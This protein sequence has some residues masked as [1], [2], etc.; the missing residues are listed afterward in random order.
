MLTGE[1]QAAAYA[2]APA[3]VITAPAGTGKTEVLVRRAEQF[4]N[5]PASGYKRVL[6]VT[7]TTRA[8]AEFTSRLQGSLGTAMSRVQAETVHGFAQSILTIHGSHVGLP[9]DFQVI[10]RDEDRAELLAVYDPSWQPDDDLSLFRELDIARAKGSAHPHLLAWSEA[11]AYRGAVDFNE[12]ITKA[13]QVLQINAI[14]Q[15]MRN[16][17]G[18]VLVDEA[19][20]LTRQQYEFI[21]ALIGQRPESHSPQV[22]TTLLGDPNQLVTGF[23]GGDSAHMKG[24][25][26]AFGATELTL[27]K[28]FRSSRL[29]S[30]LEQVV[31]REL[32]RNGHHRGVVTQEASTGILELS[33]FDSQHAEAEHIAKWVDQLL[34]DGLPSEAVMPQESRQILPEE[35]AVLARHAASLDS[36]SEALTDRG[37]DIARAHSEDDYTSSHLGRIAVLL[38]R[39]RSDRHSHAAKGELRRDFGIDLPVEFAVDATAPVA[40][41]STRSAETVTGELL[42]LFRTV[43]SPVEFMEALDNCR[44]EASENCAPLANWSADRTLLRGAWAEF[45]NVTPKRERTWT[46][47]ALHLDRMAQKRDLGVGVRVLT[48]HKAQGREFKAVTIAAMN[49]GQFPDFRATSPDAIQAERQAFYVAATRASRMLLLTRAET[50]P[51][52]YGLRA[53]EPSPFLKLVK[54]ARTSP[55]S[56]PQA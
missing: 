9:P 28:N 24:F 21:V 56:I 10:T 43:E 26:S 37:I 36:V 40:A 42:A 41:V 1:Q 46:R 55:S 35:I 8:A 54:Q 53:T 23:A 50:R 45:A 7:Y 5:D 3:L 12:M 11:L 25:R 31:S 6:V 2:D 47:F 4:V 27:S 51:T 17:Y 48:V 14:A 38:M 18:L 52:R 20:N 19:Q 22:P 29:L 15:M 44:L 33:Q 34:V 30:R 13:T 32:G 49:D 16:V 39:S